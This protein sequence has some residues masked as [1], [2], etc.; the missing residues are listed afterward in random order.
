MEKICLKLYLLLSI[1]VPQ[2][3]ENPTGL[4]K[5]D[6]EQMMTE[7]KFLVDLFF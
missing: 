5:H 2:K 1:S 7:L 3:K 4:E 6:D